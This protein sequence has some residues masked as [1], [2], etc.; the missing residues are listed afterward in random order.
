MKI[1]KSLILLS[2]S[3]LIASCYGSRESQGGIYFYGYDFSTY[4]KRG[5]LITPN[6]YRGEFESIGLI[7]AEYH[8]KVSKNKLID[9]HGMVIPFETY[10]TDGITY[11]IEQINTDDVIEQFYQQA[12][13]MGADAISSFDITI[14]TKS[15]SGLQVPYVQ[16]SG[17]AIKRK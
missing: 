11:Y 14:L 9:E 7:S 17:F 12:V 3:L 1:I 8:P 6:V 10:T 2:I 15:L 4:T 13:E 5:F 16:I